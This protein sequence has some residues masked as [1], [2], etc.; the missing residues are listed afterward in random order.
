MDKP[1]FR[2]KTRDVIGIATCIT[3]ITLYKYSNIAK[4]LFLSNSHPTKKYAEMLIK[5]DNRITNFCGFNYEIDGFKLIENTEKYQSYRMNLRGIRGICKILVKVQKLDNEELKFLS[6]QQ[7]KISLMPYELRK[8][9]PFI[10]I[11]F[12]D[13]LIPCEKAMKNVN[14]RLQKIKDKFD[15]KLKVSSTSSENN[16]DIGES[17][18]LN[19]FFNDN[20]NGKLCDGSQF[21]IFEKIN[22]LEENKLILKEYVDAIRI[23]NSDSFYR[24]I[25]I[26]VSYSENAIFNIRPLNA[27]FRDYEIIDTE[28]TDKTYLDIFKK[29]FRVQQQYEYKCNYEVSAEEVKNELK[30]SKQNY[31]REKFEK[32][33]NMFK[34]QIIGLIGVIFY[35]KQYF[36][37]VSNQKVYKGVVENLYKNKILKNKLGD[38]YYIPYVAFRYNLIQ[39]NFRF[40]C[41]A[42][43]AENKI[44]VKGKSLPNA[45]NVLPTL[46]YYDIAKSPLKV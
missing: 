4:D 5:L 15:S 9:E 42:L 13:V 43:N 19:I 23:R 1:L 38:N 45:E 33:K 2:F 40:T 18:Q 21:E 22:N 6:E 34:W 25:N 11:D 44:I 36:K 20:Y 41:V 24:F 31:F 12:T 26:S 32:R 14:E 35:Y 37:Y 39:K 16:S 17:L 46:N 29:L 30:A 7:K 27:K 3:G 28:F 10:P 8:K